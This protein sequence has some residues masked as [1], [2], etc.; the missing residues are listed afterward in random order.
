MVEVRVE[1]HLRVARVESADPR[2][3]LRVRA[4]A[5]ELALLVVKGLR[6]VDAGA[7]LHAAGH[8]IVEAL[9]VHQAEVGDQGEIQG[10]ARV[11]VAL[12]RVLDHLAHDREIGQRLAALELQGDA[13]RG[14]REREVHRAAGRLGGHVEA[15][16]VEV[17]AAGVAVDAG[18]V[19][20]Q[21]HHQDVQVRPCLQEAVLLTRPAHERVAVDRVAVEVQRELRAEP[22][23]VF[24]QRGELLAR[25]R[26]PV[27]PRVGDEHAPRDL[28]VLDRYEHRN[29]HAHLSLAHGILSEVASSAI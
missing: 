3:G 7:D 1:A 18:L 5:H 28:A 13:R 4:R 6:P 21:G 2:R 26:R 8:E 19:A 22:L 17:R 11:L 15:R 23:G 20:A 16:L 14:R 27:S 29:V 12:D 10:L 25:E 9:V 24:A